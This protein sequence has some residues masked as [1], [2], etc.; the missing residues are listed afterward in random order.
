MLTEQTIDVE[1]SQKIKDEMD[2][3]LKYTDGLR[4]KRCYHNVFNAIT[5]SNA[6]EKV[7]SGEWAI[8][9]GYMSSIENL[10]VRH[11]Y[12]VMNENNAVDPTA[13]LLD[14]WNVSAFSYLTFKT[15]NITEYLD[16]LN[17]HDLKP[18]LSNAFLEEERLAREWAEE[19][20]LVLIG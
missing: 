9:Y 15:L 18:A 2:G 20:S 12:F 5:F 17:E 8:A 4:R 10:M 11:C 13:V 7:R 19:Q 6:G 16:L 14:N 1:E 3:L